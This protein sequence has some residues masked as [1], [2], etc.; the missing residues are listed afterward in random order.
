M[1]GI[2]R[3][4]WNIFGQLGSRAPW[5][6]ARWH[7]MLTRAVKSAHIRQSSW[8]KISFHFFVFVLNLCCSFVELCH[9][10]LAINCIKLKSNWNWN[11]CIVEYVRWAYS[12]TIKQ[13]T[14]G[15]F[16]I[17]RVMVSCLARK[18]QP[19]ALDIYLYFLSFLDIKMAWII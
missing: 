16:R 15:V 14:H 18:H 1:L 7:S 9:V 8:P 3:W 12:N 2:G 11:W 5:V 19:F 10:M 6:R 13:C 17:N 4:T